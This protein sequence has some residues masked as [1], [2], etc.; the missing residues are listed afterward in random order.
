MTTAQLLKLSQTFA[1]G[2][3]SSPRT[4][5]DRLQRL[6][7]GGFIHRHPL[8]IL[9]GRGGGLPHYYKL[10]PAGL[11][12]LY[13]EDARPPSKRFFAPVAV[14]RHHHTHSLSEF[15]VTTAV[16]AHRHGFR[17]HD[18]HPE[19]M[20]VL[21][22]NGELLIPDT[23]FDLLGTGGRFQ[24]LIEQ[25]CS[26]ETIRSMKH[27]DTIHRKLRLHDAYRDLSAERHRV[28]FVT[29]RSRER[30]KN[31][32]DAAAGV[33]RNQDRTLFLG[34][35]LADYVH[36]ADPVRESLFLDHRGRRHSLLPRLD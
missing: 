26:T 2:P 3:F 30:L 27:D 25:D 34:I 4:L 8:A 7:Q 5:L 14:A 20:L 35:Y 32:L 16:A 13:G 6:T 9:S 15:L 19:N 1:A 12:M 21:D 11:R 24:F 23:R 28:V 10:T 22:V 29:S 31:I 33:V 18:I 36:A 17:L